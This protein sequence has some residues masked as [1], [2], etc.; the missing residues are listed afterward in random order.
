MTQLFIFDNDGVLRD[1][2]VSYERCVIETVAFFDQGKTANAKEVVESRMATNDDWER[3]LLILR[4][5]GLFQDAG[6]VLE[7][8]IIPKFQ[9]LYLGNL[10]NGQFTGYINNEPWLADNSLLAKLK[11]KGPLAIVSGA[12]QD[13]IQ[14]TLR[15]NNAGDLFDLVLGMHDI[16]GKADGLQRAVRHFGASETYFCDDRPSGV[17]AGVKLGKEL[18]IVTYGIIPPQETD[19]WRK[20]LLDSG[21]KAVFANVKDYCRFLLEK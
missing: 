12:P 1:E 6:N 20:V 21:V 4:Q 15:K 13:E 7:D 10:V 17:K 3:T 19:S 14:Y 16:N 5:R 8:K 9:E 18:N 2:S 11:T